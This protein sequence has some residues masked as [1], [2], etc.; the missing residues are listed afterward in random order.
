MILQDDYFP[1]SVGGA[2][3]VAQAQAEELARRGYEVAVICASEA[4]DKSEKING[5]KIYRVKTRAFGFWQY[6]LCLYNPPALRAVRKILA[7]E[8]PDIVHCHNLHTALSYYCLKM[9]RRYAKKVFLT[10]HD[11]M[12]VSFGKL[13][14]D[15]YRDKMD[16]RLDWRDHWKAVGKRYNPFRNSVI[17]YYLKFVDKIFVVSKSLESAL[18]ANGIKNTAVVYNGINSKNFSDVSADGIAEFRRK[19]NLEN[20]KIIFFAARISVPKGTDIV[21]RIMNAIKKSEAVLL[22][23][24][25]G[26]AA[27][28]KKIQAEILSLKLQE[29]ILFLGDVL[30]E[31]MNF[32]YRLVDLVVVPSVYLDPFPTIN[33]EAMAAKKPVV[34]TCYGGTPEAVL[35]GVTGYI[36]NPPHIDEM[37]DKI[38]TL[39]KDNGLAE[40]FGAAGYERVN[41]YFSLNKQIGTLLDYYNS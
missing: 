15:R 12:T 36:V 35:D 27:Y 23:A 14:T 34:G 21:I 7:E 13:A 25:I 1:E 30:H 4:G 5:V 18:N 22:I 40:R 33:L 11:A 26:N 6:Y 20:K 19:N 31:R 28:M 9:A 2:G 10:A 3:I 41:Q 16:A 24:G 8:R 29:R 39:L 17:R 37:T 32:F 38:M